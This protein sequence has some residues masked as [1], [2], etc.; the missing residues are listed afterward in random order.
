[1]QALEQVSGSESVPTKPGE[2]SIM[3]L[4]QSWSRRNRASAGTSLW[5]RVCSDETGRALE[6]VSGSES[7]QTKPG[8]RWSKFLVE[9]VPTKT[10]EYPWF[11]THPSNIFE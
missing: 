1:M 2:R 3:F 4:V 8:K 11:D 7:V 5:F 6:Q 10:D 9:S